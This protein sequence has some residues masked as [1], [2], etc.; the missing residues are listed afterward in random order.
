[1]VLGCWGGGGVLVES[2]RVISGHSM[3]ILIIV[4]DQV[5]Q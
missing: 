3:H 1:M 2:G 4:R 5:S